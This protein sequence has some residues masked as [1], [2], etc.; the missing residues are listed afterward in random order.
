MLIAD[1][2]ARGQ[3]ADGAVQNED[4]H[5]RSRSGRTVTMRP[6]KPFQRRTA[7][8]PPTP[9]LRWRL[10]RTGSATS[11]ASG[12][13]L[14]AGEPSEF[15][16]L[17]PA[18]ASV[19]ADENGSAGSLQ[20]GQARVAEASVG[21]ADLEPDVAQLVR[22]ELESRFAKGIGASSAPATIERHSGAGGAH[23]TPPGRART[24]PA[25][26]TAANAASICR[27]NTARRSR[28]RPRSFASPFAIASQVAPV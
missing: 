11:V 26:P 3:S 5:A 2:V 27:R 13:S 16:T 14:T 28:S 7:A 19:A 8:R 17:S 10:G 21:G 24:H 18:R 15:A 1:A 23:R 25:R 12:S 22:V 6:G 4:R 9:V 20:W